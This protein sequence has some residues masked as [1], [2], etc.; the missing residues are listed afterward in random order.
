VVT[1]TR[2]RSKLA[3]R[4]KKARMMEEDDERGEGRKAN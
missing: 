2:V 3:D 4:K 1:K